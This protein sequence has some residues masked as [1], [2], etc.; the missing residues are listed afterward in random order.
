MKTKRVVITGM[1]AITPIGSTIDTFWNGLINGVS[2]IRKI[3]QFDA[4]ELPCQIAGEIPDFEPELYIERREARRFPR[5]AQIGLAS[6]IQAVKDAGF[7]E[8]MPDAERSGVVYGTAL[9]GI[10]QFDKGIITL[11]TLG[12][13]KSVRLPSHLEFQTLQLF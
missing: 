12:L 2:G 1:G 8:V 10:D 6:A 13:T 7:S 11:R 4:S 5:S 9:G 3:T